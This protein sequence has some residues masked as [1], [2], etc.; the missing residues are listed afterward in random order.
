MPTPLDEILANEK[1]QAQKKEGDLPIPVL[2][3]TPAAD[4]E[5]RTHGHARRREWRHKERDA[6][7]A[8]EGRIRD[9]E[10]GEY[11]KKEPPEEKPAEAKPEEKP[12]EKTEAPKQDF[13]EREKAFL[14]AAHEERQKRQALEKQLKDTAPKPEEQK[15]FWDDPEKYFKQFEERLKQSEESTRQAAHNARLHT[16]EMIARS[17]YEDFDEAVEVF[18]EALQH[19]PGLG[20]Q[21]MAAA[22]PAEF[23]YQSGKSMKAMREV[24]TI[25]ALREKIAK[26]ERAKL[27]TEM[28]A[29]AEKEAEERA[30]LPK[31]LSEAQAAAPQKKVLWGGPTPLDEVLRRE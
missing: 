4:T 26:E 23:A 24:G 11:V 25:D 1:P 14:R 21:W 19:V 2:G 15:S 20:Q 13:T 3:E 27:E 22:D 28:K 5:E 10:T 31:S 12:A 7:E 8:A 30:K 29:K 6:R 9:P 18:A 17:K 16:A